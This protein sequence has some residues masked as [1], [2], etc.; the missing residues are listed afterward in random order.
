MEDRP[1]FFELVPMTEEIE[2]LVARGPE[3]ENDPI[4]VDKVIGSAEKI[5]ETNVKAQVLFDM[6]PIPAEFEAD[7]AEENADQAPE[8]IRRSSSATSGAA[9]G[10]P[11]RIYE[12]SELTFGRKIGE[13]AFGTI[14]KGTL[15]CPGQP[16]LEVAL[17]TFKPAP[18][19][20]LDRFGKEAAFMAALRHPHLVTLFGICY[21]GR[22][23]SFV[24][25]KTDLGSLNEFLRA[26]K[27]SLSLT[28]LCRYTS[29]VPF[30]FILFFV[31]GGTL[32]APFSRVSLTLL[33]CCRP[34]G[35]CGRLPAVWTTWRATALSTVTWQHGIFSSLTAIGA[36]SV[37]LAWLGHSAMAA[38]T[39]APSRKASGPSSG[40][41]QRRS[42]SAS[43]RTP[44]MC[45]ALACCS[46]RFS[47][48]VRSPTR[49]NGARR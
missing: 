31:G 21:H 39:I 23:I 13:G 24:T 18:G 47:R 10:S 46:G 42:C 2:T 37:T 7:D 4:Y 35:G 45:G 32:C 36:R 38:T 43:L 14:F 1:S 3:R 41:P 9:E 12:L 48:L 11:L 5:Y 15:E 26:N 27:P 28:D 16:P 20:S 22:N 40:M 33:L 29:Q 8:V 30:Y 49:A 34:G 25:E 6:E 17:K 19:H 44:V